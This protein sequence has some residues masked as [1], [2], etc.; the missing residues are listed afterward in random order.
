[1]GVDN[2]LLRQLFLIVFCLFFSKL[3]NIS[4]GSHSISGYSLGYQRNFHTHPGNLQQILAN[5]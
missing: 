2:K 4:I 1:M 5:S 3:E